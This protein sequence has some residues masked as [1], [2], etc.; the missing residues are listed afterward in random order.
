MAPVVLP[1]IWDPASAVDPLPQPFRMIDKL[2][3]EVLDK[4]L[5]V[6]DEKEAARRAEEASRVNL[7]RACVHACCGSCHARALCLAGM[8]H[9]IDL[10]L[11]A[12]MARVWCIGHLSRV[13]CHDSAAHHWRAYTHVQAG[14]H[15]APALCASAVS[16]EWLL[17]SCPTCRHLHHTPSSR[18]R[19][20]RAASCLWA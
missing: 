15:S 5:A 9:T 19:R 10:L 11:V 1:P 14:M 16:A 13:G 2:V 12:N 6:V 8:A 20:R 17:L 3:A 7:V 4:V 18:R